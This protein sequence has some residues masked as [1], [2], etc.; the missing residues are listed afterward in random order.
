[1]LM[2]LAITLRSENH[3]NWT[4]GVA[5]RMQTALPVANPGPQLPIGF[6]ILARVS[7]LPCP[8]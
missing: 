8:A 6:T 1:M 7:E 3:D 5:L 4:W 2:C